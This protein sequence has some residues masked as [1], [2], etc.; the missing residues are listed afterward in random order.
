MNSGD[1]KAAPL[2]SQQ[3]LVG[4]SSRNAHNTV[5][6]ESEDQANPTSHKEQDMVVIEA[7]DDEYAISA[8]RTEKRT[9]PAV[10]E[11]LEVDQVRTANTSTSQITATTTARPPCR[12]CR[13]GTASKPLLIFDNEG[14]SDLAPYPF[15]SP[16]A[17]GK[18]KKTK[19]F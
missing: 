19:C 3:N 16:R 18:A 1:E 13:N 7:L 2:V 5:I 17:K 9:P 11:D 6:D 12:S 4:M 15:A 10:S 14:D 8:A